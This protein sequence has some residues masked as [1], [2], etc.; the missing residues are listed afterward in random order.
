MRQNWIGLA[1]LPVVLAACG[2]SS[3]RPE[4]EPV[5]SVSVTTLVAGWENKFSVDWNVVEGRDSSRV[6]EGYVQSQYGEGAQPVRLLVQALDNSGDVASQ[7]IM[8]IS[9]GLA[10]FGRAFFRSPQ[11]P[12]ADHYRV[13]VWDYTIK[14]K[15]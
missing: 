7:R 11:L 14:T 12:A 5:P 15:P 3:Y 10:G 13:T 6:V 4:S 1:V 2:T 9:G 8:W